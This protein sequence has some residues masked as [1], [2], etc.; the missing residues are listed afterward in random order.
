MRSNTNQHLL[1]RGGESQGLIVVIKRGTREYRYLL[2]EKGKEAG[3]IF[4][5]HWCRNGRSLG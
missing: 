3:S 5:A 1:F 2:Q 4:G